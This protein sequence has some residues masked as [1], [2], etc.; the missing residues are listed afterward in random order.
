MFVTSPVETNNVHVTLDASGRFPTLTVPSERSSGAVA[1][2][3]RHDPIA[4]ADRHVMGILRD[5]DPP[6]IVL[7]GLGLGYV[8]DAIERRGLTARVLAFEPLPASIP[9]FLARR[10]WSSWFESGRLRIVEGPTYAGAQDAWAAWAPTTMPP[11][12]VHP[13]VMQARPDLVPAA[14]GAIAVA[15]YGGPLD[16]RVTRVRQSMLHRKVLTMLEHAAATTRGAVV[17]I[18]AYIGGATIVMARGIRDSGRPRPMLAI[19]L[20]GAHP[21]HSDLPSHDILADLQANLRTRELDSYVTLLSGFSSDRAIVSAVH[22]C[23]AERRTQIGLLCIDADGDVQRDLDLYLPLCGSGCLLVID[24]YN[25]PPDN[26]KTDLT[27]RAVDALVSSGRAKP[28]GVFG[29]GTWMGIYA[30]AE[31]AWSAGGDCGP[32]QRELMAAMR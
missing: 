30:P 17:E 9:H 23:L 32:V 21:A 7:I 12:I 18:G 19:E 1:L 24:D 20:G 4:E 6:V 16:S 14:R 26:I 10:N 13:G 29:W 28:L 31:A 25:C 8:L 22:A 2:N 3:S 15:Q 27:K 5:T 11:V